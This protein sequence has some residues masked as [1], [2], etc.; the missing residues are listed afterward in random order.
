MQKTSFLLPILLLIGCALKPVAQNQD[1][2]TKVATKYVQEFQKDCSIHTDLWGK[3]LCVPLIILDRQSLM[4]VSTHIDP[5]KQFKQIND[6][7][8]GRYYGNPIYANTSFEWDNKKWSMVL[9]PL[10]DDSNDRK[11]L[12]FHEAFHSLQESLGFPMANSVNDHLDQ[13]GARVLLR[14]EWAALLKSVQDDKYSKSH[15]ATAIQLREERFKKYAGAKE[16]EM[17]LDISEGLAEYT[18]TKLQGL[19]KDETIKYFDQRL[20]KIAEVPSLIRSSAYYSGPLYGYVLDSCNEKW[21]QGLSIEKDFGNLVLKYCGASKSNGKLILAS[22]TDYGFSEISSFEKQRS[23][24]LKNKIKNYL[25]KIEQDGR[26]EIELK[27]PQ[28]MFNPYGILSVDANKKIYETFEVTD[29]WGH[30]VANAGALLVSN[31]KKSTVVLSPPTVRST[32]EANG[33]GW[34]LKL[35]TG[36]EFKNFNGKIIVETV[37]SRRN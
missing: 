25:V 19:N 17:A 27:S 4:A 15:L 37:R 30:F 34:A 31:K 5:K 26:L 10:S 12:L 11:K 13:E 7:F 18:G 35:K 2:F 33:D 20:R 6:V 36:Y 8:V 16:K 29:E 23:L 14:L 21:K 22:F 32:D 1:E 9:W 24:N 3:S 28:A